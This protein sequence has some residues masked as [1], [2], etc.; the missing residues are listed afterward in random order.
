MTI[1]PEDWNKT[2]AVIDGLLPTSGDRRTYTVADIIRRKEEMRDGLLTS[3]QEEHR[4]T[5]GQPELHTSLMNPL[6]KR[7]WNVSPIRTQNYWWQYKYLPPLPER[8]R[9]VALGN[10]RK[11]GK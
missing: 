1:D 3:L 7:L 4:Q 8:L 9:K 11:A 2:L 10:K 5:L 6:T